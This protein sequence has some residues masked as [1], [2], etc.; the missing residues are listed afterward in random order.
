[1]W[2]LSLPDK[3]NGRSSTVVFKKLLKSFNVQAG[4]A[5]VYFVYYIKVVIFDLEL[6]KCT[7]C[8]T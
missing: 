2:I 6:P 8:T 3:L 4:A 1:M 7:L 5:K